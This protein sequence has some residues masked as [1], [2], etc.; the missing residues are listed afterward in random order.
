MTL[1]EK[2]ARVKVYKNVKKLKDYQVREYASMQKENSDRVTVISGY[3]GS[4]KSFLQM[5]LHENWVMNILKVKNVQ[6]AFSTFC[7]KDVDWANALPYPRP[8]LYLVGVLGELA[9]NDTNFYHESF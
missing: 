1:A 2:L 7:F 3:E 4:G 9:Y 8:F 5:E 6:K